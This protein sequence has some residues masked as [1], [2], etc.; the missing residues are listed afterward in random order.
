M[1]RM[2]VGMPTI[3]PSVILSRRESAADRLERT[4]TAVTAKHDQRGDDD[5]RDRDHLDRRHDEERQQRRSRAPA[6]ATTP[7]RDG[8][9]AQDDPDDRVAASGSDCHPLSSRMCATPVRRG[10]GRGSQPGPAGPCQDWRV[11]TSISL[12]RK[13]VVVGLDAAQEGVEVLVRVGQEAEQEALHA[14]RTGEVGACIP[15]QELRD[16]AGVLEDLGRGCLERVVAAR[17][18]PAAR[19]PRCRCPASAR[20]RAAPQA[21]RRTSGRPWRPRGSW[22]WR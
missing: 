20:R 15:V 13:R 19:P 22:G 5:G 6:S 2:D 7:T 17:C 4:T 14:G 3:S 10:A 16:V 11:I 8:K 1:V 9:Q 18:R 21:W 12:R